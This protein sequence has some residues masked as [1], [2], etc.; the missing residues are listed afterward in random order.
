MRFIL[1]G[2]LFLFPGFAQRLPTG[3][4]FGGSGN[5]S[6]NAT[7]VDAAGNI[8]VVGTT[9]SFD[10]PL[11]NAF[12]GA[13]SGTQ[14][15]FSTDAGAS[16]KPLETLYPSLTPLQPTVIAADP[17]NG[18]ALYA[19]AGNSVCKS[20]D[21]GH[22]FHCST[23]AFRSFQ[24]TISSLAIDPAQPTTIYAS[25][26]V[27]G[28]VYKS[29][30]GGETWADASLGLPAPLFIDSV[31]IDPFHRNTL[32]AWA[33]SGGYVSIDGG[34]S[35]TLSS[36]PWPDGTSLSG[37]VS[38]S[39]DPV[40]PGVLYG[41]SF[42]NG[43]SVQKS[44][45]GGATWT[46]LDTPFNSCCVVADPKTPGSVYALAQ[47]SD[48]NP[49]QFWK[50]SDGGVSWKSYA[51]PSA[52]AGPLVVD[53]ANPRI[54]LAGTFRSSDGGETWQPTNASRSIRA[55]FGGS[56]NL[57]YAVAPISSDAFVA[58]FLPDGK[59]LV[60][61]TYFG[62]MGDDTGQGI[63]LDASGDIWITGSTASYDFPAT[64]GAF[65]PELR[66]PANAYVA[67]FSNDGALLAAS[68]LG[69]STQD[70]GL[71]IAMGA[72]GNP[73]L[74]GSWTSA[75]FVF[76]A[77]PVAD[78][79]IP[80]GGFVAEFDT[81]ARKLLYS[82]SVGGMFD[83]NGKGIAIDASG[84]V[85]LSGTTYSSDFPVR[86]GAFHMS[87]QANPS[88]GKAFVLKLAPSGD[89]IY[90][91]YFGGTQGPVL[92]P[93]SGGEHDYGVAVAADAAGNAYITGSTSA[94]DFPVTA[95]AYQTSLGTG[96]A[97]P[98]F[99]DNTGFIGTILRWIVDDVFVVKLSPDGKTVLFSTLLGGAC[100]DRPSSIALDA[101]GQILVA[102]ETDSGDFP[103][104]SAVGA[105]PAAPQFASFVAALDTDG[106][107][108]GTVDV[109]LRGSEPDGRTAG[110]IDSGGRK[111][112]RRRTD[113]AW[114]QLRH[115]ISFNGDGWRF[116]ARRAAVS[117]STSRRAAALGAGPAPI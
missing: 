38:F 77:G 83:A 102:G 113:P 37:G 3:L 32:Y 7:A 67:K 17:S 33:G 31:A 46:Q 70:K 92:P 27:N 45:D 82:S 52:T 16:W 51:F 59:T 74:I 106:S 97:Y 89:V 13:N 10:L 90:S 86:G 85:T 110:H 41:P 107:K 66:G 2:F 87:G 11:R 42:A 69:G 115:A 93:V 39:F 12:Q 76:T 64:A 99:T 34:G 103:Q 18:Q 50:S 68:Y 49:L 95:G 20:I 94:T 72:Q 25:A 80:P 79:A 47:A 23:I 81:S 22:Q 61:S 62:G 5:D 105:T 53:P 84:N 63:A 88:S 96:C 14:M 28:G 40:T 114:L 65:Q 4:R 8:Y 29:V 9:S 55:V 109:S 111:Q 24:T 117:D 78:V 44:S 15:I 19:A 58:K 6:I 54:M 43:L 60:F 108:T 35:W 100:Y 26:S 112:R 56:A 75:D 71:G 116:A 101:S 21:G 91:T 36:L 48:R 98:A 30:D 104:V 73:W 57:V 1:A